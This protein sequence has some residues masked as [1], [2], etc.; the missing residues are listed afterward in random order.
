[1]VAFIA[2]LIKSIAKGEITYNKSFLNVILAALV[3]LT[4]VSI[5]LVDSQYLGFFGSTGAEVDSFLN[6]ISF[7]LLFFLIAGVAVSEGWI[8]GLFLLSSVLVFLISALQLFGLWIFP[9]DF[10]KTI[11]F[12]TIGTTNALAIFLGFVFVLIFSTIYSKKFVFHKQILLSAFLVAI[13]ALLAVIRFWVPFVGIVLAAAVFICM[14]FKERENLFS[15]SFISLYLVLALS[16]LCILSNFIPFLNFNFWPSFQLPLE[17]TPSWSSSI[18]ILRDTMKENWKVMMFGSGPSTFQYQ[19][20]MYRL[21][22][23]NN[24]DFWSVRF[25]QGINA[26]ITNVVNTGILGSAVFLLMLLFLLAKSIQ[27]I[28]KGQRIVIGLGLIYLILILFL[29]P[30]NFVLYFFLFVLAALLIKSEHHQ[31]VIY[32]NNSP[33]KTF[34]FSL[35]MM[36]LIMLAVSVLYVQGKRY[37]GSVYFYSGQRSFAINGDIDK[38]LSKFLKA[39]YF[40]SKND[41]YLQNLAQAFMIKVNSIASQPANNQE[42][43]QQLQANFSSNLGGAIQAAK[44]ATEVNPNESQNWQIL[45]KVYEDVIVLV[46][47]A[48]EKAIEAYNE[49]LK[50]EPNSPSIVTALGRSHLLFGD[51]YSRS[52]DR[53]NKDKE[54]IESETTLEKAIALKPDYLP[55]HFLMAQVYERQGRERLMKAKSNEIGQL[56]GGDPAVFYQLGLFHYR[57]NR[58]DLAKTNFE[59]AVELFPNYSNARYFLGLILESYGQRNKAVEQFEKIFELNPGNEQVKEML[60]NLNSNKVNVKSVEDPSLE[61]KPDSKNEL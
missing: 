15:R 2:F 27:A 50:L 37:V 58:L 60:K 33:T 39:V 55:A 3:V 20:G 53:R 36:V 14:K 47:G 34:S 16:V 11:T 13:F 18:S 56:S 44:E 54:F 21:P 42:G 4:G 32:I 41:V 8:A 28:Y 19:Y 1:M 59:K 26:F 30:Q 23:L 17:V 40:D 9:W 5:L 61:E 52:D 25:V 31:R 45:G 57:S 22:S 43:L 6:I 29:Y 51:F 35:L 38:T 10:A 49:A 12:N 48:G 7:V 46:P 24:S